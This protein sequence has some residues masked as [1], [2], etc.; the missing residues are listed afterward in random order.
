MKKIYFLIFL[1]L[2]LEAQGQLLPSLKKGEYATVEEF[3]PMAGEKK[4]NFPEKISQEHRDRLEYLKVDS[5]EGWTTSG[6]PETVV[7]FGFDQNGH[8][9]KFSRSRR[10]GEFAFDLLIWVEGKLT[11]VNWL[12]S[13]CFNFL[14]YKLVKIIE[15]TPPP[16]VAQK[17]DTLFIVEK[18]V[19]K[20]YSTQ[21]QQQEECGCPPVYQE[22]PQ[23]YGGYYQPPPQQWTP[24]Y[25]SYPSQ[26]NITY[27][28]HP[29]GVSYGDHPTRISYG[30][31]P[32]GGSTG[33]FYGN[34]QTGSRVVRG[35][36]NSGNRR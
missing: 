31:I 12:A 17:V 8:F 16:V 26:K 15:V 10:T 11:Q 4:F 27:G 14:P 19:E 2:G 34:H 20:Y 3:P 5:V 22:Q 18:V 24:Y 21:V 28:D 36:P 33:G 13:S 23:Q 30:N 25:P 9:Q 1:A 6:L 7:N 29:T 32:T 35:Q